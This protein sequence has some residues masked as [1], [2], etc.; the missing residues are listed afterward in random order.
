MMNM[1]MKF[2]R[3][4]ALVLAFLT[5]ILPFSACGEEELESD[6]ESDFEESFASDEAYDGKF[7]ILKGGK[8]TVRAI[9]PNLA[10]NVERSVYTKLRTS[11]GNKTKVNVDSNTD[12]LKEGES[13]NKNE[14]VIL[15]GETS[16]KESAWVYER[17]NADTYGIQ[18]LNGNRMV[19][20]FSTESEGVKLVNELMSAIESD[21]NG[22]FWVDGSFSVEKKTSLKLEA[23][24]SY[25]TST[26]KVDC[27]DDTTM[28][29]AKGT[30]LS[31]Y[32]SYCNT[33]KSSGY[34]EYSR[35]DNVNGNYYRIYTKNMTAIN[36]YFTKSNSSVRIISG[37]IDD[38][39]SK[40]VDKTPETN[41][42]VTVTMLSQGEDTDCGL[43]LIIHLPN[44]KFIIF[45]G[46]FSLYDKLYK[47]LGEISPR[48]SKIT[49]AAWFVSHPHYD[50]QDA[51]TYFI[52]KHA[53]SVDVENIFYNYATKAIYSDT[54]QEENAGG[55]EGVTDGL[56]GIVDSNFSRTTKIIK[57]HTGQ[58]YNFGSASAEIL[59]T[60]EDVV[61]SKLDY[62]N[63][64]SLVVRFKVAG[65][66]ILA[67]ADATHT[68]STVLQNNY[69]SYLKSDI[70]QI[71][72]HGT[73]P[74][75]ASLYTK[76][77]AATLLWPSNTANAKK[78]YSNDAVREALSK[79]KDVYLSKDADVTLT[80]PYTVKNNKQTFLKS[81]GK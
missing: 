72:H 13:H 69:G 77:N 39:P 1:K 24:P 43:G 36:V 23:A 80:L 68:V 33:L 78:Q 29:Y 79:A 16:Y 40:D 7:P 34:T 25:P 14:Y 71:A 46:G 15:V 73:Y 38:I 18:I 22:Y 11:L 19:I 61:P 37:P 17:T 5:F 2:I 48:G 12:F 54:T 81:I 6:S 8:Y 30:N 20:Y 27:G 4:L 53:H 59:Y 52:K 26:T 41:K 21:E 28:L 63:S 62:V 32:E 50:H 60:F 58:V 67:L 49:V 35:R 64:S 55:L 3:L 66:T 44:G 56:D 65:Q 75:H 74:G 57:P 9:M 10:T 51:V 31:T 42:S 76:I 45:D 47:K 70:V